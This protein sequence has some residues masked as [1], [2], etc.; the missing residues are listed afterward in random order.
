MRRTLTAT[1]LAAGLIIASAGAA[2]AN[3]SEA[4]QTHPGHQGA[5]SSGSYHGIP[6]IHFHEVGPYQTGPGG[7]GALV[8]ETAQTY[9]G[10]PHAH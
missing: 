3:S 8:A 6:T 1:A 5:L 2:S 4:A 7:W 10:I 9:K